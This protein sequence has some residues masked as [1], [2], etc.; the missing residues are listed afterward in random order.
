MDGATA[1]S[2]AVAAAKNEL[3]ATGSVVAAATDTMRSNDGLQ[4]HFFHFNQQL[5]AH[6]ESSEPRRKIELFGLCSVSRK[7]IYCDK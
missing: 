5:T 3:A 7:L 4:L 2:V 1:G 6:I